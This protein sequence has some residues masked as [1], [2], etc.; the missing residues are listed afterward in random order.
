MICYRRKKGINKLK[1][2]YMKREELLKW[3]MCLQTVLRNNVIVY[4]SWVS[5]PRIKISA[6]SQLTLPLDALNRL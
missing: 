4:Y 6:Y 2:Q 3:R 1:T 5:I